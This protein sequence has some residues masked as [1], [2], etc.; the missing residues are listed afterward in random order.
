M[1][2]YVEALKK[3]FVFSGRASRREF[4][5][6][7]LVTVVLSAVPLFILGVI[8]EFTFDH[9]TDNKTNYNDTHNSQMTLDEFLFGD[10]NSTTSTNP[11]EIRSWEDMSLD[12]IWASSDRA[13]AVAERL[14]QRQEARAKGLSP[15]IAKNDSKSPIKTLL[16]IDRTF[17]EIWAESESAASAA[18][19]INKREKSFSDKLDAGLESLFCFDI[20]TGSILVGL[21]FYI[22]ICSAIPLLS[23]TVRRLH[24]ISRSGWNLGFILFPPILGLIMLVYLLAKKG[25]DGTNKY[26]EPLNNKT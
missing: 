21:F 15:D 23:C 16:G 20:N 7:A 24:D 13:K 10:T 22:V 5:W 1:N 18:N 4:W 2:C 25:D 19:Q 9:M 8:K 6:F 14:R 17:E 12:E 26:G 11:A 3:Y